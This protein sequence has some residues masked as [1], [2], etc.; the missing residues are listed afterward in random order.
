MSERAP[1]SAWL[2]A[3]AVF[4]CA[5]GLRLLALSQIEAHYP[6]AD[7]VVIDEQSY[8]TWAIEIAEGDWIGDEVFFQEPLYPYWIA[9]VYSLFGTEQRLHQ[10]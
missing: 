3:L 4:A 7:R 9:S 5:L 1:R 10:A 2:G 8:E 6:L